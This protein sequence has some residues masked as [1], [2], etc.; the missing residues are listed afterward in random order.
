VEDQQGDI[1]EE[2][3]VEE[4]IVEEDRGCK[5]VES[6]HMV[7]DVGRRLLTPAQPSGWP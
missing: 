5:A 2:D 7:V 6:D 3:I 4:D 1:V